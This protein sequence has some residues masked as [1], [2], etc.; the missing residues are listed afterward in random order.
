MAKILLVED[1]KSLAIGIMYTFKDEGFECLH[2]PT[3]K[4]ARELFDS[5]FDIVVMDVELPDGNGYELCREIR[6]KSDVPI[7]FLTSYDDE[8][9]IVMGLDIGGDDYVTKPFQ[10][11]VLMSRIKANIRRRN[12]ARGNIVRAGDLQVNIELCTA[13][14]EGVK[15]ELTATE[16]R[17]LTFFITNVNK[18]LTRSVILDRIWDN[19]GKYIDDNTVSVHIRH[20]REKLRSLNSEASIVTIRGIG[21]R[22]EI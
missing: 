9:N 4:E 19:R 14:V 22:M 21:Y 5:S 20:I 3:A 1:D 11:K 12:P 10:L 8:V 17:L 2:A 18:T 13:Y 15:L 16:M 6:N 7:I